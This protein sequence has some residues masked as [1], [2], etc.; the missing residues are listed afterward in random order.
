M[1][2]S[3][4]THCYESFRWGWTVIEVFGL[5]V[6]L[7]MFE[8]EYV[9]KYSHRSYTSHW[10]RHYDLIICHV[11]LTSHDLPTRIGSK[12]DT[13]FIEM[14]GHVV[15][16]TIT[17]CNFLKVVWIAYINDG[18]AYEFF[19]V[20]SQDHASIRPFIFIDWMILLLF[21]WKGLLVRIDRIVIFDG[22]QHWHE[23]S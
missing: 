1:L 2:D 19:T 7:I 23:G 18:N 4:M 20:L 15:I 10:W 5:H 6:G 22:F 17:E 9:Q 13:F 14:S 3:S 16:F 21:A 11:T 8:L 12:G